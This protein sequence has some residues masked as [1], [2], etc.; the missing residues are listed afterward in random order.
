MVIFIFGGAGSGKSLLLDFLKKRYNACIIEADKTAHELYEPGNTGYTAVR[1]LLGS[2]ILNEDKTLDR[3]KMAEI[4]YK[5][6]ALIKKIN[7][8]IHPMVWKSINNK[9]DNIKNMNTKNT[10]QLI[11]VEA[12]LIPKD[13]KEL[14]GMFD[15]YWFLYADEK[16]RRKRLKESRGY[17]DDMIDNIISKQPET[18]DY[19]RLCDVLI[20]N[21]SAYSELEEKIEGLLS[22]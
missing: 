1:N 14:E 10:Q 21:N 12:A 3:K 8:V 22:R 9:I 5:D 19:I 13:R 7:S 11:V 6:A 2:Q 16:V 4:L 17:T 15:E 20:E 18:K